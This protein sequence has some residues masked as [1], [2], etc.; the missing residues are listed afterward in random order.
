MDVL[1]CSVNNGSCVSCVSGGLGSNMASKSQEP[2][3]TS[4]SD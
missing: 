2:R 3:I 4:K 1:T